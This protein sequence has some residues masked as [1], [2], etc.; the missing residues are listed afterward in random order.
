MPIEPGQRDMIAYMFLK[1]FIKEGFP[2]SDPE[3]QVQVAYYYANLM[4]IYR[5]TPFQSNPAQVEQP[6]EPVS[7][8]CKAPLKAFN[9]GGLDAPGAS[10]MVCSSCGKRHD[11]Q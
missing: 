10:M 7:S 9:I 11:A 4:C 5:E 3:K 1:D 2:S 8:C 6:T